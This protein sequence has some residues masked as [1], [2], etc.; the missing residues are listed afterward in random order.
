MTAPI[1]VAIV[2]YGYATRTFHA[3]LVASVDG[4]ELRAMSSR[5]AAKVGADWPGLVVEATP[6]ALFARDDI[7]LVVI[8]TPNDTH[9]PLARAALQAGK[10]VVVDKPFT[11]D[12][13]QAQELDAL[14]AT[15]TRL[16]SVFHNRRWDG[17]F[18]SVRELVASGRLGR[19]THFE[20]R[21]DRYRPQVRSRWREAAGPGSG[22]WM[23]HGPHLL[24]QALQLFGPPDAIS[25]Q[26]MAQRD[27]ALTDDAFHARLRYENGPCVVL[28]ASSLAAV[29]GPRLTV[30]GTRGSFVKAG[31][32][33]QEEA[34]KAGQRP[35][36]WSLPSETATLALQDAQSPDT[37]RVAPHPVLP[38]RY[39]AYYEGVRDAIQGRAPNP[40]PAREAAEV[41]AWLELGAASHAARRELSLP[42]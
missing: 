42:A 41:M 28:Q 12:L 3:P 15:G 5:D 39:V 36:T 31:A 32:D 33:P 16:L 34:L 24:D 9:H 40:V 26:V 4:L 11:L 7:D 35:G 10:H 13:A 29:A 18:L 8:P 22:V 14:A 38:G 19:I 6:E 23:D 2:G 25:L 1:R 37:V 17:D 27:G 20:S 21:V 30:H